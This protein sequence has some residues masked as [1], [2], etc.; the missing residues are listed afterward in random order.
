M[1]LVQWLRACTLSIDG[2]YVYKR[3]FVYVRRPLAVYSFVRLANGGSHRVHIHHSHARRH[4][5]SHTVRPHLTDSDSRS[6]G[7]CMPMITSS[8]VQ[9]GAGP[10]KSRD[11]RELCTFGSGCSSKS[12]SES[13]CGI[14]RLYVHNAT[15]KRRLQGSQRLNV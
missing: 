7:D 13:A 14:E 5:V 11:N 9:H 10:A 4:S 1:G 2:M 6:A 8:G 3:T 12:S 15:F